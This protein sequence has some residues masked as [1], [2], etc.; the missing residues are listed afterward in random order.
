MRFSEFFTPR[1]P[2]AEAVLFEIDF[3]DKSV[4]DTALT[5]PVMC[6]FEAE[7]VWPNISVQSEDDVFDDVNGMTWDEFLDSDYSSEMSYRKERDIE[8]AWQEWVLEEKLP[9]V[10]LELIDDWVSENF[11]DYTQEYFDDGFDDGDLDDWLELNEYE[12]SDFD[13]RASA[14][15]EFIM[16]EHRSEYSE[17]LEQYAR[18]ES[19]VTDKALDRASRE[20]DIDSWIE[21]E[22][23]SMLEMLNNNDV[24][25]PVEQSNQDALGEV[26]NILERSMSVDAVTGEYHSS[27]TD[28]TTEYWRVEKDR[29]IQ[30]EGT[31][32]EIISPVYGSP[33]DMLAAMA[34]LF[35]V[36]RTNGVETSSAQGTG[37][38]V[39][40]SWKQPGS[41]LNK[42]K[43]CLLLGDEHVLETFGRLNNSYAR[44]QVKSIKQAISG[45]EREL[46]NST[47]D[48]IEQSLQKGIKSTK[49]ST[50]NFKGLI[51]S[52]GNQLIEFRAAGGDDYHRDMQR[53]ENTVLRYAAVMR[54]GY[55][56]D[57]H[58]KDYVLAIYRAL[59]SAVK[60]DSPETAQRPSVPAGKTVKYQ[61]KSYVSQEDGV[62]AQ[63]DKIVKSKRLINILND[64]ALA[65][66]DAGKKS[67]QADIKTHPSIKRSADTVFDFLWKHRQTQ[68]APATDISLLA[69]KFNEFMTSYGDNADIMHQLLTVSE[70]ATSKELQ[71]A[72]ALLKE[73]RDRFASVLV[74]FGRTRTDV[75]PPVTVVAALKKLAKVIGFD[76]HD[77]IESVPEFKQIGDHAVKASIMSNISSMLKLKN[78]ISYSYLDMDEK[79][80]H[81]LSVMLL[82]AAMAEQ[83]HNV[84][85]A[86]SNIIGVLVGKK[87]QEAGDFQEITRM[88]G[89]L[90]DF[91]DVRDAINSFRRFFQEYG[92]SDGL[93]SAVQYAKS[94]PSL[95]SL[96][97]VG[98]VNKLRNLQLQLVEFTRSIEA[99]IDAKTQAALSNIQQ[100]D[101][102]IQIM[103]M[104]LRDVYQHLNFGVL[105]DIN[106]LRLNI[107]DNVIS[108]IIDDL[109]NTQ[110]DSE[111][112]LRDLSA[113]LSFTGRLLTDQ[114]F[115]FVEKSQ[116]VGG[117][118]QSRQRVYAA[119][120]AYFQMLKK[121]GI[122]TPSL[123]LEQQVEMAIN[124]HDEFLSLPIWEQLRLVESMDTSAI[125]EAWSKKYRRSIDCKNPRGFSQRAHC[126][127]RRKKGK[128]ESVSEGVPNLDAERTVE[129]LLSDHFPVGDIGKQMLAYTAVPVPEMLSDFRHLHAE[130]GADACARGI[131]RNYA[132]WY[133]SVKP[134]SR[135]SIT[136]A[137]NIVEAKG[138][139]GRMLGDQFT[140]SAGE[141]LT[142]QQVESYPQ[143]QGRFD[144]VEQRDA[145]IEE[146]ESQLGSSIQWTNS[147]NRASLAFG[148]ATLMDQNDQPVYWGRYFQSIR[149]NMLGSWDNKS[150]P[151]GWNLK[152]AASEKMNLGVD[153][154]SLIKTEKTFSS[155]QDVIQTVAANSADS[156]LSDQLVGALNS[157]VSKQLPV[158]EE[159]YDKMSALRDYFGEIMAPVAVISEMVG[160]QLDDAKQAL[161]PD[162][163]WEDCSVFWPQ[164]MNYNLADS[165]LVT[166]DGTEIVISSKGGAGAKASAKNL[167]DAIDKS[168]DQTK[169]QYPYTV[170]VLGIISEHTAREA[171]FRLAEFLG[172]LPDG[173]ED[174]INKY[175]DDGKADFVG[176][177]A[178]ATELLDY[179]EPREEIANFNSG[180]ALLALLAKKCAGLVNENPEFSEG[181]RAFLNNSSLIQVYVKMGKRG[182][183]AVVNSIDAIFPPNF[184]GTILLDHSKNYTSTAVR[185]KFGFGFVK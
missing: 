34:Q 150:V 90:D 54:A 35:K 7:T 14:I 76:Y 11:D 143:P 111:M 113:Y 128:S 5:A 88:F 38:H 136:E 71:Q 164:S 110:Q 151:V 146:L 122:K 29:T 49:F 133:F 170:D 154:Q 84:R 6:G 32:A 19:M 175:I 131:L 144:S 8:T 23:G 114:I 142:F 1:A 152:K 58:K 124:E 62:W 85:G 166:P 158:F 28:E 134:G 145:A 56:A 97:N 68:N 130:R 70:A 149:T 60:A 79:T 69:Y 116:T 27:D 103:S 63:D 25:V 178:D 22:Y 40:M 112:R 46:L 66:V 42:L 61:N 77:H 31:K 10:E 181:A 159:N 57:A 50:I 41:Q 15:K 53:I 65:G 55:D 118:E 86:V 180:Y 121:L 24:Y 72:A 157:L 171:P 126:D 119:F 89:G 106:Q 83:K 105:S 4:R 13:D 18:D 179:G 92:S 47:I 140:N 51:N 148:V 37:L 16:S 115:L 99:V 74:W 177:S 30:G 87:G 20:N 162:A 73:V 93:K 125:N 107:N 39:T 48:E 78:P 36:F 43:M 137:V 109:N 117:M 108:S 176:I 141:V 167:S 185:G 75:K 101:K 147:A 129:K 45:K 33:K 183:T 155:V 135:S 174:E 2:V 161:L 163:N 169:Q 17:F 67:S 139:Y 59:N 182:N 12:R 104:G 138:I 3:N 100:R 123:D 44:S 184:S 173:L 127:G 64:I 102:L 80:R 82:R 132:A 81:A 160:G 165:M 153:P 52:A 120:D 156:D 95:Q 94:L 91:E 168:S 26:A 9:D 172:V 98:E 96:G 21:S